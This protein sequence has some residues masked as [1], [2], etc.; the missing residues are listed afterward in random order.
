[1]IVNSQQDHRNGET[2]SRQVSAT[3]KIGL[4]S[5]R[6]TL[7][8]AWPA[9]LRKRLKLTGKHVRS[10]WSN[11]LQSFVRLRRPSLQQPVQSP[12]GGLLAV[13]PPRDAAILADGAG[14]HDPDDPQPPPPLPQRRHRLANLGNLP[15]HNCTN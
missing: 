8:L 7:V 6:S 11:V 10:R 13:L 12:A 3:G 9:K 15:G 14:R 4:G 2:W 1:M 5:A